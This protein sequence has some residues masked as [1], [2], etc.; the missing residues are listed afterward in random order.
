MTSALDVIDEEPS[1]KVGKKD[2]QND[3]FHENDVEMQ[4]S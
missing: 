1:V 4:S 2:G 3:S